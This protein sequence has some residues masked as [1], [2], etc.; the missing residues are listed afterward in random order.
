MDRSTAQHSAVRTLVRFS[1]PLILSGILQQLYGWVDAFVVGHVLG[2]TALA[3]VGSTATI[4]S[5]LIQAITGFTLGLSI[6]AAQKYGQGE[7]EDLRRI[8]SSFA[9]I[10]GAVFLVLTGACVP[11]TGRILTL[12]HTPEDMFLYA[13]DY[14]WII[15]LGIPFLAVY[16]TYAALLRAM[17]DS[18]APFYAVTLSSGLNVVLDILLVA[19]VPWGTAGAAAATVV[20]QAA[21]TVF[22]IAYT[23]RR[24]PHL[25]F[26]LRGRLLHPP[27]IASAC[28]FSFPPAI[29]YSVTALG[30]LALQNFM[31][32]FGSQTVAAITSA[33]RIDS[34]MLLPILN[35]GAAIST[36]IAQSR[37]A[38]Q[39]E[40]IRQFFRTGVLLELLLGGVLFLVMPLFGGPLIALFGVEEGAV[41]IG[42]RFF[43]ALAPF[44]FC[45]SVSLAFR[46]AAEGLGAMLYAG[47]AGIAS[48]GMRIALSY[49]LAPSLSDLAISYAEGFCW[50][51]LLLLFLPF[52]FLHRG[53]LGIGPLS[54]R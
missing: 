5:L 1:L 49:L 42:S 17:G 26:S 40:R 21:M 32:G 35:L 38:R 19:V 31:N 53:E 30:N 3:A 7:L 41:A 27:V 46:G 39:P 22:L 52:L 37:G 44:Y 10:L 25:R 48:L 24:Y 33:Y 4:T 34:V 15:F 6:L 16:N 11:L 36:M 8:L 47:A 13:F 51:F 9:C 18:R 20:S 29:Q 23:A 50:I 12:M 45:F 14:L 54:R 28:A 2:E 43:R